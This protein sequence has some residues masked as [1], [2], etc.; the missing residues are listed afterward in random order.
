MHKVIVRLSW[1]LFKFVQVKGSPL[2]QGVT[3][4]KVHRQLNKIAF[5]R[6]LH[7]FTKQPNKVKFLKIKDHTPLQ[8]EIFYSI[9]YCIFSCYLWIMLTKLLVK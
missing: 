2:L 6:T 4:V 1:N 9:V 7:I 3:I 8:E 5:S